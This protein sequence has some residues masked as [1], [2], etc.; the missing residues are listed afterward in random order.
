MRST[1]RHNTENHPL[2]EQSPYSASKIGADQ[3]AMSFYNSFDTPV[4]IL[5]P[6]NI[7]GPRQ[8]ARAVIPIII[9]P[10]RCGDKQIKLGALSPIQDFNYL[11]DTVAGFVSALESEKVS[12]RLSILVVILRFLSGTRF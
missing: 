9:S 4:T 11:M 3:I 1:A 7:Y 12:G 6:F 8:S 10:N 2:Q 5:R